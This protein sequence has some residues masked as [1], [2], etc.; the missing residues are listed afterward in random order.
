MKSGLKQSIMVYYSFAIAP[1]HSLIYPR[2]YTGVGASQL[3]V[4]TV[5]TTATVNRLTPTCVVHVVLG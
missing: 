4:R 2:T 1:G 3:T 5:A